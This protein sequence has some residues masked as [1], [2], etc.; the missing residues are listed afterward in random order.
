MAWGNPPSRCH[1]RVRPAAQASSSISAGPKWY[2]NATIAAIFV[3]LLVGLLAAFSDRMLA[4]AGDGVGAGLGILTGALAIWGI[5]NAKSEG[6]DATARLLW[7]TLLTFFALVAIIGGAR[8]ESL[9]SDLSTGEMRRLAIAVIVAAIL[10]AVLS[11]I[12]VAIARVQQENAIASGARRLEAGRHRLIGA[13]DATRQ[14]ITFTPILRFRF[15]ITLTMF[16]LPVR[17]P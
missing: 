9:F 2:R 13:T 6:H 3:G 12:I 14:Q 15:P 17:S 11:A 16:A 7:R 1:T 10:M 4:Q 5:S 8:P